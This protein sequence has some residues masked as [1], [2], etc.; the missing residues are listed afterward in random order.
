MFT[1]TR[2]LI[3]EE[4]LYNRCLRI[5]IVAI[6]TIKRTYITIGST[7][8]E[9]D[10]KKLQYVNSMALQTV[11]V[12]QTNYIKRKCNKNCV[13]YLHLKLIVCLTVLQYNKQYPSL[14]TIESSAWAVAERFSAIME[15]NNNG[16]SKRSK[17]PHR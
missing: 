14:V 13:Q 2:I 16:F 7:Q 4:Q 17:F 10:T 12:F 5:K 11:R 6:N 15:T 3:Y 1:R 9:A 8:N